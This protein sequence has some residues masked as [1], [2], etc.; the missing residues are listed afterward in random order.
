MSGTGAHAGVRRTASSPRQSIS[1]NHQHQQQQR[2]QPIVPLAGEHVVSVSSSS[3]PTSQQNRATYSAVVAGIAAAAASRNGRAQQQQPQQQTAAPPPLPTLDWSRRGS[4]VSFETSSVD[5]PVAFTHLR[6]NSS[7]NNNAS[8]ASFTGALSVPQSPMI[9]ASAAPPRSSSHLSY[10][11][12]SLSQMAPLVLSGLR[13]HGHGGGGEEG[14]DHGLTVVESMADPSPD[15]GG[16]GAGDD[17][18][19]RLEEE[20]LQDDDD[21]DNYML[22]GRA[23]QDE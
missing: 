16:D 3:Q 17:A 4:V 14:D 8:A 19:S 13:L 22:Y 5:A 11:A 12:S 20:E 10:R 2:L 9:V 23:M 6:N 15:G 7:L 18:G 1:R 21:D